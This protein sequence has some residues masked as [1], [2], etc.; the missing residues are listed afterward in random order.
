[1][2]RKKKT[3]AAQS[4]ELVVEYHKPMASS[5]QIAKHFK[6]QH[7]DVL[8][9]IHGLTRDLPPEFGERNFALSNY[10]TTQGKTQ[11]CYLLTRDAFSLLVMGFTGGKALTWKVSYIEAFNRME[12]ALH[13]EQADNQIEDKI[14]MPPAGDEKARQER[15]VK[16]LRALVA[17]WVSLENITL[18][19]AEK[20]LCLHLGIKRMEDC[21]EDCL[22]RAWSFVFHAPFLYENTEGVRER[23]TEQQS[24]CIF[25]LVEGCTQF[26]A[27]RNINVS[28]V[29]HETFG[30]TQEYVDNMSKL[31]ANK[32]IAALAGLFFRCWGQSEYM[33]HIFKKFKPKS[34]G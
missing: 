34:Q 11:P 23:T 5:M 10:L 20:V 28:G 18:E 33:S 3:S 22:D 1:M 16:C 26:I 19:M 4:I 9:D 7:K 14:K 24:K 15:R 12:A 13:S 27:S 8:R 6:K 30:L 32:L 31:G 17:L 2:P 29:L 21:S 25:R